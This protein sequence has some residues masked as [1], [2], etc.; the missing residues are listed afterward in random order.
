MEE[1]TGKTSS[2]EFKRRCGNSKPLYPCR[3]IK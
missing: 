2:P 1:N 3:A